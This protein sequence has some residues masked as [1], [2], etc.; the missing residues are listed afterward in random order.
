[1][2]NDIKTF[3]EDHGLTELQFCTIYGIVKVL[4]R[5]DYPTCIS[6][7]ITCIGD[8]LAAKFDNEVLTKYW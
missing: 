5:K 6:Y 4:I 1:M 3:C 8:R 7:L 2:K